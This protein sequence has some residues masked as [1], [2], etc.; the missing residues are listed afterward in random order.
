MGNRNRRLLVLTLAIIV[1]SSIPSA[2]AT[3]DFQNMHATVVLKATNAELRIGDNQQVFGC[4]ERSI[5]KDFGHTAANTWVE[6]Y[7]NGSVIGQTGGTQVPQTDLATADSNAVVQ[8]NL[9]LRTNSNAMLY[10]L[11]VNSAA[12][13]YG[14][15]VNSSAF[16]SLAS[17]VRTYSN[18]FAYG[19]KNNSNPMNALIGVPNANSIDGTRMVRYCTNNYVFHTGSWTARGFVR[20]N[21]GFTVMPSGSVLMDTLTTVSGGFDLGDTGMLILNNDLYLAH[22]VT[23][24]DGGNIKGKSSTTPGAGANTIFMGGDLKLSAI[25]VPPLVLHITG[26]W[27]K[28]GTSGDT[29]IDGGGHTLNIGDYAQIFVDQNVTLTLRNMTIKTGPKSLFKPAI[30]LASVGS[31]LA[32]DNVLLDLGADFHFVSGQLFIHD[33]VA[34]TGTSAFVYQSPRPSYITSGATWSFDPSTTFSIAPATYTDK[35]YTTGTATTNN[36]IVHADATAA[37]SLNNCS[38]QTTF[39]GLRLRSG[40]VLF[41]DK[42]AV[43]TQA[44]VDLYSS[45][46]FGTGVGALSATVTVSGVAISPDQR[47]VAV[48]AV[49]GTPLVNIYTFNGATVFGS[50]VATTGT[51]GNNAV[52]AVAWSS[53]ER[54]VAV[55]SDTGLRIYRFS[56]TSVT[57]VG[58]TQ[59]FGIIVNSISWSPDGRYLAVGGNN[60]TTPLIM[61]RFSGTGLTQ[62]TTANP[63]GNTIQVNGAAWS[64]DGRYV[65]VA[66]RATSEA[67][68]L[69][70]YAFNGSAIGVTTSVVNGG[71]GCSV[72]WSPDGRFL[73]WGW[74]NGSTG[75]TGSCNIYSFNGTSL[76]AIASQTIGTQVN[77]IAWSPNA[78]YLLDCSTNG[79]AGTY[80]VYKVNLSGATPLIIPR[81][82]FGTVATTVAW[83]TDSNYALVGGTNTGSNYLTVYPST[84]VSTAA[85]TQGF[86]NGLIFGNSALGAA[87]DADVQVWGGASVAIKGMVLDDSA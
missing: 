72:A 52:P 20:F 4:S 36:F 1:F 22:N 15:R 38:F 66:A 2:W 65:A 70:V 74:N 35:S 32:L 7:A 45:A 29:V 63:G 48:A 18:A 37:L 54:F 16:V 68:T 23:L 10:T 49:N 67:S 24:T 39:T 44:G 28:T 43:N 55:G 3:L 69:Y 50:P 53:D 8:F 78:R 14:D 57:Q 40:M 61:Y 86:S 60:G 75:A 79:T 5:V 41:N 82:A 42:V 13:L 59:S 87:Y 73:A 51:I 30:Q 64:P 62:V 26:D 11:R 33:E 84:F 34:V 46:P 25:N 83:S 9:S 76:T 17:S 56:G 81:P 71:I 58:S 85:T 12:L 31:K 6:A 27:S 80:Q 21:N 77:A 47:Y 19:I